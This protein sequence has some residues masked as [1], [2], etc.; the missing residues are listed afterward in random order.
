MVV[1]RVTQ[2]SVTVDDRVCGR[3]GP[4]L[5]VLLGVAP[6]DT[7]ADVECLAEKVINLRVFADASGKMNRSLLET[8]YELLLVSQFTLYADCR[9]GRRPDFT[10]AAP[11]V[12]A[13]VLYEAMAA[14]MRRRHIPVSTG[15]FAAHM[16]V[17][18][19]NDGPVTI[20]LEA[21]AGKICS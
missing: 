21:Q 12:M 3:I 4:G 5:L 2:A 1:Q 16:L 20:V 10:G 17:H 6:A 13:E 7:L 9:R 19:V 15:V 18:L 8:G 11:P 14:S